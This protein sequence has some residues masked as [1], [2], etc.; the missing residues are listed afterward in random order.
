MQLMRRTGQS[1]AEYAI[2]FAVV[3]AAVVGMQVYYKRGMQAKLKG[4]V[5]RLNFDTSPAGEAL[6]QYEPYYAKSDYT[7]GQG[8]TTNAV[9]KEGGTIDRTISRDETTRTGSASQEVDMAQDAGWVPGA[10]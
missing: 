3:V 8:T 2:V 4:V 7:V 10:E 5:D 1:T 9:V 6:L